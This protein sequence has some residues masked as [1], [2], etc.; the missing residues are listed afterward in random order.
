MQVYSYVFR[1]LKASHPVRTSK[2]S[3]I[4]RKVLIWK[5]LWGQSLG[6]ASFIQYKGQ[7]QEKEHVSGPR[8]S[9][10]DEILCW[11]KNVNA[12]L[13]GMHN[14]THFVFQTVYLKT[15]ISISQLP[16]KTAIL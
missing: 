13:F 5:S 14:K 11:M 6:G 2:H 3:E 4:L 15:C 1:M 10:M 7:P 16:H 12:Y 9:M 8:N